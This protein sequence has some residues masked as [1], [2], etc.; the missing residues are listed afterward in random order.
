MI[1]H[2][3]PC[4]LLLSIWW[5]L[6]GLGL[7]IDGLWY[8]GTSSISSWLCLDHSNKVSVSSFNS[9]MEWTIRFTPYCLQGMEMLLDGVVQSMQ[10]LVIH[11]HSK[12]CFQWRMSPSKVIRASFGNLTPL[13]SAEAKL[14]VGDQPAPW[15]E[16]NRWSTASLS[17]LIPKRVIKYLFSFSVKTECVQDYF[18]P[19]CSKVLVVGT[20]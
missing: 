6:Q 15:R 7:E 10:L 2:C 19:P 17:R 16:E 1:T 20:I 8:E 18:Q 9:I 13:L 5:C 11:Q 3:T 4:V 14:G 12:N